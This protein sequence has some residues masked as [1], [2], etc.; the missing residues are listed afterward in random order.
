[1]AG[2][3]KKLDYENKNIIFTIDCFKKSN[4][5]IVNE[6]IKKLKYYND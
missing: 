1:L 3:K 5:T 6:I 2:W 4:E